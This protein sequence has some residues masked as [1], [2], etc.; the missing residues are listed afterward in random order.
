VFLVFQASDV[1]FLFRCGE[2]EELVYIHNS[3]VL[4]DNDPDWIVYQ[5]V[6]ESTGKM[7]LRGVTAI[8][9]QWIP[10]FCE[11]L[12]RSEQILTQP[13]PFYDEET[14]LVKCHQKVSYGR[15]GWELPIAQCEYPL[16]LQK[17]KLFAQFLLEG[18]VFPMMKRWTPLLLSL[19][20]TM[21]KP[22]A[23][24]Q[25]RTQSFLKILTDNG[26]HRKEH[27]QNKWG[28]SN[29]PSFLLDQYLEWVPEASHAEVRK[30]WP[31]IGP[32]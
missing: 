14:G 27:L 16:R 20:I 29:S 7:Y 21:T 3:S 6:F 10:V 4:Y 25:P 30:S 19:P 23:K 18:Q 24:L 17:Y 1:Y 8:E 22:W 5:E 12:C 11:S 32:T 26:I 28:A 2:M 31:P 15:Q 9:P 13:P